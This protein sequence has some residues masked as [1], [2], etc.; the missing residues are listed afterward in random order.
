MLHLW[1]PST[2]AIPKRLK[3]WA[4]KAHRQVKLCESSNL[5]R[6]AILDSRELCALVRRVLFCFMGS[7]GKYF[8]I[9][10]DVDNSQTAKMISS[11]SIR[12]N[13]QA[14]RDHKPA[15]TR[16]RRR[17]LT[18]FLRVMPLTIASLSYFLICVKLLI[19]PSTM[20]W[21]M[22][23]ITLIMRHVLLFSTH[24]MCDRYATSMIL[25]L[26]FLHFR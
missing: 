26:F 22:K 6:S 15:W 7:E 20:V 3:G 14:S 19:C 12:C 10:I 4:W 24:K 17:P 21:S 5:S 16:N 1:Q 8:A 25:K 11:F 2:G 13:F 23:K 18:I 9:A